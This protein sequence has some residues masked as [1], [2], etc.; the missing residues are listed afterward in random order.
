ML[1]ASYKKYI[2]LLSLSWPS[3]RRNSGELVQRE[4]KPKFYEKL[5]KLN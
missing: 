3:A 4:N 5:D 2:A 1:A